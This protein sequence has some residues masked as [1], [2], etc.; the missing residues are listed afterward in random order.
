MAEPPLDEPEP[1]P[2]PA[3]ADETP[4]R[5]WTL[6]KI[7]VVVCVV[8]LT[9]MWAYALSGV[10]GN[11]VAGRLDDRSFGPT[12]N[13]VCAAAKADIDALPRSFQT[14]EP[15][16]RADVVDQ[17]T[18]RLRIM[19]DELRALP[20]PSGPDGDM[21][22]QWLDDWETYLANR[23]DYTARLRVDRN[24]RFYVTQRE[25]DKRQITLGL[26]RFA[27]INKMADCTTPDD[28]A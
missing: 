23:D 10:A 18:A 1:A 17:G 9:A 8:G 20:R 24:A 5:R 12:A 27:A 14:P 21:I 16:D 25:A 6:G 19:V 4:R 3:R 2:A 7:A 28:V 13:P 11:D 22:E 15:G 26:D